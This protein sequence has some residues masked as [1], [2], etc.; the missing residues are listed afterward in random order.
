MRKEHIRKKKEAKWKASL[1]PITSD[2]VD[3][4]PIG[5]P[6]K[7]WT[8]ADLTRIAR[9]AKENRKANPISEERSA[10]IE[11]L[12]IEG[13]LENEAAE[14]RRKKQQVRNLFFKK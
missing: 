11:K 4:Y 2:N 9:M 12:E 8:K 5:N 14:L 3:D 7:E 10:W 6:Y 13:R 1:P